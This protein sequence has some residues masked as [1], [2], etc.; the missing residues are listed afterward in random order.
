MGCRKCGGVG[1][2][3]ASEDAGFQAGESALVVL[4]DFV[5]NVIEAIF[6]AIDARVY[7]GKPSSH[8]R[9][10]V[11]DSLSQA[12]AEVVDSL[13]QVVDAQA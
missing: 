9:T 11:I 2:G 10:Q 1:S 3:G 12:L 6:Q 8:L 4:A 5:L 7:S 13:A